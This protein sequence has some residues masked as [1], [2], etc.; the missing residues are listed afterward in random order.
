[1]GGLLYGLLSSGSCRVAPEWVPEVWHALLVVGG[2]LTIPVMVALYQVVRVAAIAALVAAGGYVHLREWLGSYR[3]L[4]SAVPG[5]VVVKAGFPITAAI[6]AVLAIVLIAMALRRQDRNRTTAVVL[7]VTAVFQ[8]AS[9]AA[10][11]LSR[12]DSVFGWSEPAWTRGADQI[13]AIEIGAL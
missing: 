10:L 1:M 6:S 7:G 2:L 4:P 5:A 11:I 12:T 13:R 3:S 9:L 8:A